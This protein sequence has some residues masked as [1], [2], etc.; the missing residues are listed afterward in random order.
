MKT[1]IAQPR[2]GRATRKMEGRVGEEG[3]GREQDSKNIAIGFNSIPNED[4]PFLDLKSKAVRAH[5]LD[6]GKP[7]Q[8]TCLII[9]VKG[10]I[11]L[12]FSGIEDRADEI[13]CGGDLRGQDF[14]RG[15]SGHGFP[16]GESEALHRADADSQPREGARAEGDGPSIEVFGGTARF[17]EEIFDGPEEPFGVGDGGV[18]EIF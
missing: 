3:Q 6:R 1:F 11:D 5:R 7:L 8:K 16:G 18:E 14:E 9:P 2:Y 10:G 15:D 13:G 4:G 12:S 17:P